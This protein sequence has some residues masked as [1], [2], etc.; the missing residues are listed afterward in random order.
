MK[1]NVYK[2]TL[3]VLFI[4]NITKVWFM[5]VGPRVKVIVM[6]TLGANYYVIRVGLLAS[7]FNTDFVCFGSVFLQAVFT[8]FFFFSLR[9]VVVA[10]FLEK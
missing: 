1:L 4:S 2:D 9:N 6:T 7:P 10:F 3:S 8:C 5:Q